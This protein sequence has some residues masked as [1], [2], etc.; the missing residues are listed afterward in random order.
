MGSVMGLFHLLKK[1]V[2]VSSDMQDL[3]GARELEGVRE[4]EG[5][6]ELYL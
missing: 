3:E 6:A 4:I 5:G 2:V 1:E